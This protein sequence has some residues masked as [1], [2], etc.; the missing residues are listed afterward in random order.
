MLE[1]YTQAGLAATVRHTALAFLLWAASVPAPPAEP[2][3]PPAAP[4]TFHV[5]VVQLLGLGAPL[6]PLGRRHHG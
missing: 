2:A 5:A 4:S 6:R 3:A 1:G